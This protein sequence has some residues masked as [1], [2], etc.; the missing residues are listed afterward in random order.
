MTI[1]KRDVLNVLLVV[2]AIFAVG[3]TDTDEAMYNELVRDA[4]EINADRTKLRLGDQALHAVEMKLFKT[5]EE[6]EAMTDIRRGLYDA[7][8]DETI[9]KRRN[10]NA[11]IEWL[12]KRI[13]A[14][15]ERAAQLDWD[16]FRGRDDFPTTQFE[17]LEPAAK[18]VQGHDVLV[19]ETE[20]EP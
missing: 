11:S 17:V 4:A 8:L 6:I 15:N 7:A 1:R 18:L 3:C 13:H 9:E 16:R 19:I 12:N 10:I 20:P 5:D 2:L 14:Y